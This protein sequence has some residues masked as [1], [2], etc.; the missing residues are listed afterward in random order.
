MNTFYDITNN[1]SLTSALP[2]FSAYGMVIGN[3]HYITYDKQFYSFAGAGECSY[4]LANDF[5]HN[6]F[7]TFVTYKIEVRQSYISFHKHKQVLQ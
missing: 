1:I 5:L 4:L 7:S 2:P 6:K 3:H